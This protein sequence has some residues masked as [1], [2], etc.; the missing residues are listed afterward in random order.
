MDS[1]VKINNL[2]VYC[3]E[4]FKKTD[5]GYF[6]IDTSLVENVLNLRFELLYYS[7]DVGVTKGSMYLWINNK[8]CDGLGRFLQLSDI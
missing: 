1:E 8:F 6:Q 7:S 4:P 3:E 2:Y 5:D